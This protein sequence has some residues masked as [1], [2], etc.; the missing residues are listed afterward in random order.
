[1]VGH[2][3]IFQ[4]FIYAIYGTAKEVV[5]EFVLPIGP[6]AAKAAIQ[7]NPFIAAVNRCATQT[8]RQIEFSASSKAAAL[9]SLVLKPT[10]RRRPGNGRDRCAP[11][12][13][14]RRFDKV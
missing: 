3:E 13:H 7:N 8:Q 9:S 6:S 12:N 2:E 1:L 10:N 5:E 14:I 11:A 4:Y